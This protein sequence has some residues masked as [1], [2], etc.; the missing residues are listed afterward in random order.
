[1]SNTLIVGAAE[2][3]P[4]I[5]TTRLHRQLDPNATCDEKNAIDERFQRAQ[6][7]LLSDRRAGRD[8]LTSVLLRRIPDLSAHNCIAIARHCFH[9][10]PDTPLDNA[11]DVLS[12]AVLGAQNIVTLIDVLQEIIISPIRL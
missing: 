8:A 5:L 10:S 1:M 7:V 2:N 11:H 9:C 12:S 3:M 6:Q 4:A